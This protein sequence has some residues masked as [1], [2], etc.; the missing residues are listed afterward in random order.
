MCQQNH[1]GLSAEDG[2]AG[3]RAGGRQTREQAWLQER[4]VLGMQRTEQVQKRPNGQGLVISW[5]WG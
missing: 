5:M 2:L 4:V 3:A 1:F